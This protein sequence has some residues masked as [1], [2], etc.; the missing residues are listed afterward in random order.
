[1]TTWFAHPWALWLLAVLPVVGGL[2]LWAW[3]KRR[4][5]LA[6][7]GDLLTLRGQV[8]VNPRGRR[9]GAVCFMAGLGWLIVG[10]AGPRWGRDPGSEEAV[11]GRD[12]V[13]VLDLSRSMLAEQPSRQERARRALL[14]LADTLQRHGGH[15]VAL[16]IFAANPKLVFPLTSD[17]DHFRAAL[18]QLDADN[19]PPA[20][21]PDPEKGPTSGTRIG[22]ALELAVEAHDPRFAGAQDI[23]LL[24]DGDDPAGDDEW[25]GGARAARLAAIPVHAV[26][27][28]DPDSPSP[29]PFRDGFLRHRDEVVKTLLR[30]KP[31]EDIAQ[32]TGGTYLRA[33]TQ[34]L[35]LGRLFHDIIEPRRDRPISEVESTAHLPMQRPRYVWFLAA[36]L[37]LLALAMLVRE[38]KMKT[39]HRVLWPG[40]NRFRLSWLGRKALMLVAIVLAAAAP[41][42]VDDL[43]RRGNAAYAD[44]DYADA[45]QLYEQAEERATDPGLVAFNKAAALYRLD[46]FREA[47]LHYRRCLEDSLAPRVVG[48]R[49]RQARA[50]YDLGNCLLKQA[51][52]DRKTIEQALDCY[53]ESMGLADEDQELLAKELLANVRHNFEVARLLW[54]EARAKSPDAEEPDHPKQGPSKESKQNGSASSKGDPGKT[55]EKGTEK[56]GDRPGAAKDG[57]KLAALGKLLVLPDEDKLVPLAPEDTM[58]FLD[59][60]RA[61]V[62]RERREYRRLAVPPSE[63]V[64]D[65]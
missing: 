61:R 65:W 4:Q 29:I 13:V 62:L 42:D 48:M 27:L 28:G 9:W 19:L 15:R 3:R 2:A 39:A 64:K 26:G 56:T 63:H 58:H 18:D 50:W 16:V 5:A 40:N 23:L 59:E 57:K 43:L 31:L 38:R 46:R 7:L 20:L 37:A 60:T 47:E 49:P 32:H 54:L 34:S 10:M 41:V 21:R 14:D 8:L 24:S 53:R 25:A 11:A 52:D 12:L 45:L 51:P 1:M 36:A 33:R 30:E 17:Y 35:P 44:E 55:D 22:A 6:R